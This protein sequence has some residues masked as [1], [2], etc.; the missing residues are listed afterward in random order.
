VEKLKI[1]RRKNGDYL[2]A[3]HFEL[4]SGAEF[5]RLYVLID[6]E[7]YEAVKTFCCEFMYEFRSPGKPSAYVCLATD[8]GEG[9]IEVI[10]PEFLTSCGFLH[11]C[12]H[13]CA[14]KKQR[15]EQAA[16][17]PGFITKIGFDIAAFLNR[18]ET[19]TLNSEVLKL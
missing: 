10:S 6:G 8:N 5:S 12:N 18:P 4:W 13:T 15:A 2:R 9:E 11:V 1:Q 17:R 19:I 14:Y 3:E 7:E 16:G